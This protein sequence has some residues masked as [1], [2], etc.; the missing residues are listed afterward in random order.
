MKGN[1]T[2][3]IPLSSNFDEIQVFDGVAERTGTR[4]DR[5]T[6]RGRAVCRSIRALAASARR[7]GDGHYYLVSSAWPE[8]TTRVPLTKVWTPVG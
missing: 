8:D 3:V 4:V 2:E 1:H 6:V 5:A 7:L